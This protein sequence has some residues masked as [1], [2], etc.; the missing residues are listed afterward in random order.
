M[1]T[2]STL[3]PEAASF[4]PQTPFDPIV[5]NA[6]L[7]YFNNL[8]N[9]HV[10]EVQS[11]SSAPYTSNH[12]RAREAQDEFEWYYG[13]D[14]SNVFAWQAILRV[15][16][17]LA[18]PST[19][20]ECKRVSPPWRVLSTDTLLLTSIWNLALLQR[21]CEHLR[22]RRGNALRTT[23]Q[24]FLQCTRFGGLQCRDEEDLPGGCGQG[25]NVVQGNVAQVRLRVGCGDRLGCVRRRR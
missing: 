1:A 8:N 9:D 23:G 5:T 16:G 2:P 11:V 3:N 12:A 20:D 14:A 18:V 19:L 22:P 15:C 25:G 4:V 17:F 21:P 10:S 7:E 13:V 24:D 6:L